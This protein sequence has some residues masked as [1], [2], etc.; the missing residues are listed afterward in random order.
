MP[1]SAGLMH[2][3]AEP[4]AMA[5][6]TARRWYDGVVEGLQGQAARQSDLAVSVS[7]ELKRPALVRSSWR[8]C[9]ESRTH[10]RVPVFQRAR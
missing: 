4:V 8:I 10:D 3:S 9:L 7:A 5:V 2:V 1:F 6:G